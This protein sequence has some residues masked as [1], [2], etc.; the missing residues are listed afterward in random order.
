MPPASGAG[1]DCQD[2]SMNAPPS[3]PGDV[4]LTADVADGATVA[5]GQDIM[6]RL[7]WD[8]TKWSGQS[9][10]EV[11]QCIRVKGALDG[12]LS[13]EEQPAANDGMFEYRLHVPDDIRPGCDICAQGF[14][15]G[16]AAGGGPQDVGSER[17]CFMSGPAEPPGPPP[18]GPTARPAPPPAMHPPATSPRTTPATRPATTP[19]TPAV[20]AKTASALPTVVAGITATRPAPGPADVPPE[21]PRT[22]SAVTRTGTAGGG[23]ALSLGGLAV[24]GGSGRRRR[25]PNR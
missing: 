5:P 22:G 1:A 17:H 9:L 8:T 16:T 14:A 12:N 21:L 25:R 2:A 13:A 10:D 6:L 19:A 4:K 20:P 7:T 23:L 15:Q 3:G 11:L 18:S 24:I